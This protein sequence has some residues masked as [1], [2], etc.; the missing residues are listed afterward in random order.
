MSEAQEEADKLRHEAKNRLN[1]L[2]KLPEGYSSEETER[3]VDCII[4]AAVLEAVA[5]INQGLQENELKPCPLCGGKAFFT[6]FER[7]SEWSGE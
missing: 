7:G 5:I 6:R 2:M 4:G 3:L 1:S